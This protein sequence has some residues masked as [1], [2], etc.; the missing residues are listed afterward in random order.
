M[1]LTFSSTEP[2]AFDTRKILTFKWNQVLTDGPTPIVTQD[3]IAYSTTDNEA[4]DVKNITLG[5]IVQ[6][7]N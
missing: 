5:K 1:A 4:F 2:S 6:K 7:L 3:A